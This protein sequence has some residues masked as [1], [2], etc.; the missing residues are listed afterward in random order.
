MPRFG[1][2]YTL[3]IGQGGRQGVEIGPPLRISF[4]VSK[5]DDKN[6]NRSRINVW[7]LAPATRKAMER[8]DVRCA[9]AVG[10]AEEGGPADLFTG[11]VIE[12]YSAHQGP[13]VVTTLELGE[14]VVAI[15]DGMV[16]LGYGRGTTSTQALRDVAG[17]MGL[18]LLLPAD[19]PVRTWE[20]GLAFHGPARSALDQITR[21]SGL[22]W[23]IQGGTLQVV[24]TGGNTN[25]QVY[26]LSAGSGLIAS[27]ERVRSARR[28]AAAEVPDEVTGQ[29]RRV[30]GKTE[31]QDGWR[32][33]SLVLPG[34][35]PGDR[36]K[37]SSRTV[38]G[39]L[40]IKELRHVGDSHGGD[41]LTE[42][43]L[44]EAT[45]AVADRRDRPPA[46]ITRA[47]QSNAG[48]DLPLP[49][50]ATPA[51]PI[52]TNVRLGETVGGV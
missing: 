48:G 50:P 17:R 32:V 4:D 44:V 12:A 34:L 24:R 51:N 15:R 16:S 29:K 23:S 11:D 19:A 10:Y 30:E 37:L 47:R 41:W 39:V 2:V 20:N 43:T 13:D 6:P 9:L 33:R 46:P 18:S 8:P 25:R 1:R 28:E 27:P 31:K 42:L 45:A 40:T 38:E 21:G 52:T 35:L 49:P 3:I 26:D 36:V 7:N 22:S 5:T 14:G